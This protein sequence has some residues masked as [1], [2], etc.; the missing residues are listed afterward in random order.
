MFFY[1]FYI[2]IAG[3]PYLNK[4]GKIYHHPKSIYGYCSI[5]KKTGEFIFDK[6]R[7]HEHFHND[8]RNGLG[9]A[10]ARLMTIYTKGLQF[11][12]FIEIATG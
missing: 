4:Y 5:N 10:Y 11:P 9:Y 1:R 7:S 2:T 6:E 12:D 3:E 8:L